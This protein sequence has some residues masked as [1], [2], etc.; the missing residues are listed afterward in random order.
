VNVL[1]IK[2]CVR[3]SG[4]EDGCYREK[5]RNSVAWAEP[6]KKTFRAFRVPFDPFDCQRQPVPVSVQYT[7]GHSTETALLEVLDVYTAAKTSRSQS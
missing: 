2:I 4:G 6:D 3:Q 5:F 7:K 1:G